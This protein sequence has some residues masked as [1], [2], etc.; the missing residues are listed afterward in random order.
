MRG[1]EEE[2]A[3]GSGPAPTRRRPSRLA[4]GARHRQPSPDRPSMKLTR[5]VWDPAKRKLKTYKTTDMLFNCFWF[6]ENVSE[7]E[8]RKKRLDFSET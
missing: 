8:M 7:K 3:Q 6:L 1:A 4:T 5:I 2:E